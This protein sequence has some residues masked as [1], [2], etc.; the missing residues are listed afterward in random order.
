MEAQRDHDHHRDTNGNLNR[1]KPYFNYGHGISWHYNDHNIPAREGCT[2]IKK[3]ESWFETAKQH[4]AKT[5]TKAAI[6]KVLLHITLR[7]TAPIDSMGEADRWASQLRN[8]GEILKKM[9]GS[10]VMLIIDL[11]CDTFALGGNYEQYVLEIRVFAKKYADR[12]QIKFEPTALLNV[13]MG[14]YTLSWNNMIDYHNAFGLDT[15]TEFERVKNEKRHQENVCYLQK[16]MRDHLPGAETV[17]EEE[18]VAAHKKTSLVSPEG[19]KERRSD[20]Y[21]SHTDA[22]LK[23]ELVRRNLQNVV[24][25]DSLATT[26]AR[27]DDIE[28]DSAQRQKLAWKDLTQEASRNPRSLLRTDATT[29]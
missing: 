8:F 23:K 28:T 4:L 15:P 24:T 7:M 19:T 5:S 25:I 29:R 10:N 17:A 18:E 21:D 1:R 2:V 12:V 11:P 3:F 16:F 20:W 14:Q 27:D 6:S 26:L 13:D 22:E 9:Q